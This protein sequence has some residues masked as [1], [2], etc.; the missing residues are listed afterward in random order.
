MLAV[1]LEA[2]YA[3]QAKN[4]TSGLNLEHTYEPGRSSEK[5]A[6]DMGVSHQSV[7]YAKQVSTKGIPELA[8][9]A[10]SGDVAV[11]ALAK[12]TSLPAE[13]QIKVVEKVEAQNQSRTP[14]Q[15]FRYHHRNSSE[16][17]KR[18]SR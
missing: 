2:L 3:E 16:G 6:R 18:R 1:T 11:S 10:S 12:V 4:R 14:S 7:S 9:L 15:Y 13:S 8:R 17:R 5:A